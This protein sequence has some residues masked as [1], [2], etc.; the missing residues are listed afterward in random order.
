MATSEHTLKIKAVL[1]SSQVQSQLQ[2][3]KTST[4][5]N[6]VDNTMSL[7]N[8][9]T[10][11]IQAIDKLP[12]NIA[13]EQKS[14]GQDFNAKAFSRFALGYGV[15]KFGTSFS[16]LLEAKGYSQAKTA[17]SALTNIGTGALAG[18]AFGPIGAGIGAAFGL[19]T[20][21][22]D[23]WTD[24][25]KKSQEELQKWNDIIKAAKD[26]E[27]KESKYLTQ[28]NSNDFLQQAIK[29]GDIESLNQARAKAYEKN[30]SARELLGKDLPGMLEQRKSIEDQIKELEPKQTRTVYSQSPSTPGGVV[31][32]KVQDAEV[33]QKIEDLKKK[34]E[35]LNLSIEKRQSALED[36][37]S[38]DQEIAQIDSAIAEVERRQLEI[39]K[40]AVRLE[41]ER[42]KQIRK[43]QER[44]EALTKA[45]E[46]RA[47][48]ESKN[49]AK[50][51]ERFSESEYIDSLVEQK[52]VKSLSTASLGYKIQMDNATSLESYNEAQQ[53]YKASQSAIKGLNDSLIDSVL[54]NYRSQMD[55]SK[56]SGAYDT[57]IN[58][59]SSDYN[60][61][62]GIGEVGFDVSQIK[63]DKMIDITT[64]IKDTIKEMQNDQK[65]LIEVTRNLKDLGLLG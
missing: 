57:S 7:N 62:L 1:D 58:S 55:K 63:E 46:E 34:L 18:S 13:K 42:E 8:A 56:N 31:M 53:K 2:G 51:R 59:F 49:L 19:A 17:Q 28:R 30:L 11:L 27:L 10:R 9:I 54:I 5:G 50:A 16:D 36:A 52:D 6:G 3:L 40:E 37:Q 48:R 14:S 26:T 24:S 21:A 29:R 32:K 4:V 20:T 12:S 25:V 61:G 35:D 47:E 44:R 33:T 64:I 41:E 15:N 45:E 65:T 23:Y 22:I 38:T 39:K 43:D 60:A